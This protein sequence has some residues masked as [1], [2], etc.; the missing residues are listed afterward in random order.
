MGERTDIN[1]YCERRQENVEKLTEILLK[2]SLLEIECNEYL[3]VSF[4]RTWIHV[5]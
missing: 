1:H 5:I 2:T 3:F 4:F